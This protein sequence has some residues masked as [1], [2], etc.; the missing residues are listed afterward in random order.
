MY[1]SD[2]ESLNHFEINNK[3]NLSSIFSPEH[4]FHCD[5]STNEFTD[6]LSGDLNSDMTKNLFNNAYNKIFDFNKDSSSLVIKDNVSP[7]ISEDNS[8]EGQNNTNNINNHID[9]NDK[10]NNVVRN[11]DNNKEEEEKDKDKKENNMKNPIFK[12]ERS[13][14][15]FDIKKMSYVEWM[16]LLV[17]TFYVSHKKG[18]KTEEEKAFIG[19]NIKHGKHANDNAR[20]KVFNRCFKIISKVIKNICYR[21]G[22]KIFEFIK[23]KKKKALKNEDIERYCRMTIEYIL[24]NN[25]PKNGNKNHNRIEYNKIKLDERFSDSLLQTI[26]NMTFG[27]VLLKFLN[28]DNFVKELDETNNDFSTFTD[29]F[30]N[31]YSEERKKEVVKSLR[32]IASKAES[33]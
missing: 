1:S 3:H 23:G 31:E 13:S 7:N 18:R 4:D 17:S 33:L 14:W 27:E 10:D 11:N 26:L 6:L 12:V 8:N 20:T 30:G 16:F 15:I 22:Y 29:N 9:S 32:T 28:D 25:K 5:S 19:N 2:E 24:V 21:M